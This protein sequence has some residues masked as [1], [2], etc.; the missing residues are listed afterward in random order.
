MGD[1]ID[2]T[3]VNG[4][5]VNVPVWEKH[6]RGS[7]WLAIIDVDG[8]KP[9]GLSR[10]FIDR[11]KGPCLYFSEQVG[12]FD[13]VE[14][15]ADYTTSV[16][17]K[18][19]RR[20]YG[21]VVGKSDDRI[22]IETCKDGLAAILRAKEARISVESRIQ[23]LKLEREDLVARTAKINEE[24]GKLVVTEP[25]PVVAEESTPPISD[26]PEMQDV[27]EDPH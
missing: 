20:F 8:T 5:L 14:F 11:G 25:E 13:A 7:N 16:G 12:L 9:G 2:L 23:A 22:R 17:R 27:H 4:T 10:H 3:I 26:S 21:V 24:L 6:E 15:G 1:L 19:P 18:R